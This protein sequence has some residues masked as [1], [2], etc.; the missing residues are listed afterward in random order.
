MDGCFDGI[1]SFIFLVDLP[2]EKLLFEQEKN[3]F[4]ARVGK[5]SFFCFCVWRG[6]FSWVY[7]GQ[8]LPVGIKGLG[9][10]RSE[11]GSVYCKTM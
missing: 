11:V 2:T 3:L 6:D 10:D 8:F 9:L 4:G 5:L 1:F 7:C